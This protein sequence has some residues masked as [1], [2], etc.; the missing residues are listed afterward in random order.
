MMLIASVSCGKLTWPTP[1]YNPRPR[2]R[3]PA[4]QPTNQHLLTAISISHP[5]SQRCNC[6]CVRATHTQHT[7]PLG[8]SA[9]PSV[10][11]A[12]GC[13]MAFLAG[14]YTQSLSALLNG[15]G[16]SLSCSQLLH[17][18]LLRCWPCYPLPPPSPPPPPPPPHLPTNPP[19][20]EVTLDEVVTAIKC[21]KNNKSPGVCHILPEMLKYGG[22]SVHLALHRVV[23]GIW[24]TEQAPPDFKQD[25][26]LPIPK[27]GDA[28]L[29]SNYHTIN[30]ILLCRALRA[31]PM[32]MCS[33]RA[34]QNG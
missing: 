16:M 31:K 8:S 25:I 5:C 6:P 24:R 19:Y 12:A 27:K 15:F 17:P 13:N 29:C 34:F 32:P 20:P 22:D 14:S 7:R 1:L 9:S 28:S 23:L 11:L 3:Q 30:A 26:L 4:E 33:V 18:L 2:T 21:L 10:R